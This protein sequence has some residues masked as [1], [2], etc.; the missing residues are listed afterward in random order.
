MTEERT[1]YRTQSEKDDPYERL[2][3]LGPFEV[4]QH[5]QTNQLWFLYKNGRPALVLDIP[6]VE[7]M[8]KTVG[9][10]RDEL[11]AVGRGDDV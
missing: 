10:L 4:A 2:A 11:V 3:D 7:L 6:E 9:R 8:A 5:K 1:H